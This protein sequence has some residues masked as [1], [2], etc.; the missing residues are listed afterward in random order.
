MGLTTG[1][2]GPV[3]L[4]AVL[5]SCGIL[6]C[7]SNSH[8]GVTRV[9]FGDVTPC[10]REIRRFDS[11][12]AYGRYRNTIANLT[13]SLFGNLV[14]LML[15]F[16][17]LQTAFDLTYPL[18]AALCALCTALCA[19][20]YRSRN[21]NAKDTPTSRGRDSPLDPKRISQKQKA[22]QRKQQQAGG[23]DRAR[24]QREEAAAQKAAEEEA[25]AAGRKAKRE[26]QKAKEREKNARRVQPAPDVPA[27]SSPVSPQAKAY[28]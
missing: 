28:Y 21:S 4:V 1:G 9:F 24:V 17:F 27:C 26:A 7:N 6:S 19:D 14:G 8:G 16:S 3:G 20:Y 2:G 23:K 5:V 25:R 18:Y 13:G 11:L 15:I 10:V 12:H 22:E